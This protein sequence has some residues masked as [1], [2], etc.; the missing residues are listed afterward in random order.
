M[1]QPR[2]LF[3]YFHSFQQQF[4]RK[5]VD[6]SGIR[7][8]FVGVEGEHADHLTTTTAPIDTQVSVAVSFRYFSCQCNF[9]W[10]IYCFKRQIIV[11]DKILS[12]A[13]N[14]V[15]INDIFLHPT[16]SD[17]LSLVHS[18]TNW[19]F[20]LSFNKLNLKLKLIFIWN[21]LLVPTYE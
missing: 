15:R 18:Y 3:V 4:Y 17:W 5:I 12:N 20:I 21:F 19:D 2:P 16:I 8:R 10:K 14:L 13:F 6:L 9:V 11:W 7:T 1:G